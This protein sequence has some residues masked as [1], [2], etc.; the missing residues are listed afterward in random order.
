MVDWQT[1]VKSEQR[2]GPIQVI[3]FKD[4]PDRALFAR[5]YGPS[6]TRVFRKL[7]GM[8]ATVLRAQWNG[9]DLETGEV[10]E[11]P[12]GVIVSQVR[13]SLTVEVLS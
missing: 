4:V 9:I 12:P 13:V 8:E 3:E 1:E 5:V 6:R 7:E 10:E 2:T 11:F